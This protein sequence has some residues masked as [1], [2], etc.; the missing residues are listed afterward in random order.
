VIECGGACSVVLNEDFCWFV[1]FRVSLFLSVCEWV[2]AFIFLIFVF[3]VLVA[4]QIPDWVPS[5][6]QSM[7]RMLLE[8]DAKKRMQLACG[9]SCRAPATE[10]AAITTS[11]STGAS[12]STS[13]AT[14]PATALQ[15][16]E[17]AVAQTICYDALRR[18]DLF[19]LAH[20][21]RA[22]STYAP[23]LGEVGNAGVRGSADRDNDSDELSTSEGVCAVY[24]RPAVQ[25]PTLRELCARAVGRATLLLAAAIAENGGIRPKTPLWMQVRA[26]SPP[27]SVVRVLDHVRCFQCCLF[28]LR[29]G[30]T[31]LCL[32]R[33]IVFCCSFYAVRFKLVTVL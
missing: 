15:S 12:A 14:L 25:V 32:Q 17:E 5:A 11:A 21:L 22:P 28:T 33:S 27:L 6:A 19:R 9:T 30:N 23:A 18:H 24:A 31:P 26:T 3:I 16:A 2:G 1:C 13:A 7:L 29:I 10:P 4:G 8:P 20:S